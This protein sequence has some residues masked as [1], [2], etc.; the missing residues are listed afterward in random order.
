MQ[1]AIG[2]YVIAVLSYFA[3]SSANA[4]SYQ[5]FDQVLKA[6]VKDGF[7]DYPAIKANARFQQYLDYLADADPESFASRDEK[8]A[9]WINAYN[10]LTIKGILDGLSP[11]GFF[12]RVTFFTTDYTLAGRQIDLYDLEQQIIIP[13]GEPRIHFAIVCASSSCPKL[14]SEAY[15]ANRLDQQLDQNTRSF[16]NNESKNKFDKTYQTA[17]ISKIFD[18]FDQDFKAG[19]KTVQQYIGKYVDDPVVAKGL[20]SNEYQ[21]FYSS[22]DWSLNGINPPAI[23]KKDL[24]RERDGR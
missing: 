6:H 9:F 18:W 10:A 8:L 16:I 15:T 5:L 4:A 14:I 7:V 21:I 19:A 17:R 24:N 11:D 22:Y 23:P 3:I 1:K 13:L 20:L 12:S 2:L